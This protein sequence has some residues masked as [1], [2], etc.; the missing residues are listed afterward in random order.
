MGKETDKRR[1]AERREARQRQGQACSHLP[2][3]LASVDDVFGNVIQADIDVSLAS[4]LD[5]EALL[6]GRNLTDLWGGVCAHE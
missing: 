4:D 3:R 6:V 2:S 1:K 5:S